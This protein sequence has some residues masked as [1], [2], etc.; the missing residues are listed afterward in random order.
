MAVSESDWCVV[1]STVAY[2]LSLPAVF[3]SL[4]IQF[5][6]RLFVI[7]MFLSIRFCMSSYFILLL[8][9]CLVSLVL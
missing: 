9:L 2:I 3:C 6:V 1:L 8:G 7:V 4:R 5:D